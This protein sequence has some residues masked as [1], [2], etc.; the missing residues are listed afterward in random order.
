MIEMLK[1]TK[2]K[3]VKTETDLLQEYAD[4][5]GIGNLTLKELI[6]SHKHLREQNVTRQKAISEGYQFGYGQG[7]M[8]GRDYA[9]KHN[10]ISRGE[11]KSIRLMDLMERLGEE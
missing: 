1:I 10:W 4:E 8:K 6:K 2:T 5:M 9:L 7:I 3:E 11:L